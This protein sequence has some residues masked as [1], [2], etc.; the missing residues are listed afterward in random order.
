MILLYI[1][2]A[3]VVY[4]IIQYVYKLRKSIENVDLIVMTLFKAAQRS[5]GVLAILIILV[6]AILI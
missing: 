6:L 3:I 5:G 4:D 1:A 2:Y